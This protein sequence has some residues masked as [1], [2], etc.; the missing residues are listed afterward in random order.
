[1]AINPGVPRPLSFGCL[2]RRSGS[3]LAI[4]L[5]AFS[6]AHPARSAA[7]YEGYFGYLFEDGGDYPTTWTETRYSNGF[8]AMTHDENNWYF[9]QTVG[10]Y[11]FFDWEWTRKL[12]KIPIEIDINTNNQSV[13]WTW[14]GSSLVPIIPPGVEEIYLPDLKNDQYMMLSV[15]D[16]A[17]HRHNSQGYL[18][19]WGSFEN[20]ASGESQSGIAVINPDT[21][22]LV[23]IHI[24]WE[25]CLATSAD[26]RLLRVRGSAEHGT[27]VAEF[28]GVDWSALEA[29]GELAL[30]IPDPHDPN[31]VIPIWD[32][33][34]SPSASTPQNCDLSP[35][36]GLLYMLHGGDCALY[37]RVE[38]ADLTIG[39]V[40]Q[41]STNSKTGD[42]GYFDARYDP[43]ICNSA[44]GEH[45]SGLTIWDLDADSRAPGIH[46][47]LHVAAIDY[48][49]WEFSV[50]DDIRMMHYSNEIHVMK[51]STVTPERGTQNY[52][53]NTLAEAVDGGWDYSTIYIW[54]SPYPESVVFHKRM[55]I[56]PLVFT[57]PY[58]LI[59]GQ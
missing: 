46:G 32:T 3:F 55:K 11:V 12:W 18:F 6:F 19:A 45:L 13:W 14:D 56:V 30:V 51:D 33:D 5:V 28:I 41:V 15:S 22:T 27:A 21:M 39:K 36:D 54:G 10:K 20:L 7:A 16:L 24:G 35:S 58:S 4:I 59:I 38:V 50:T 42:L 34:G 9:G 26:G 25:R 53:Y 29:Q 43:Y 49:H 40:V 57:A 17:Y 44:E 37:N 31:N 52:P 47:K 23:D 8:R 2:A 48:E 1:M